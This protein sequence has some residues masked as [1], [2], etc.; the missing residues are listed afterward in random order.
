M[1]PAPVHNPRG[2]I[3]VGMAIALLAGLFLS[4]RFIMGGFPGAAMFI[5][6]IQGGEQ[7]RFPGY[8]RA[9]AKGV[10]IFGRFEASGALS[11][12]SRAPLF[13]QG[14]SVPLLGRFATADGD[15]TAPDLRVPVRSL[16]LAFTQPDGQQ[17][18]TAMNTPPVFPVSSP[19]EF[20]EL[21]ALMKPDP[22]TGKPD[23]S[24]LGQ[25]FATHPESAAMGEWQRAYRPSASFATEI[26]H[27]INAFLLVDG[28]GRQ[29][30]VRWQVEPIDAARA[31]AP[32]DGPPDFLFS[33][34][35]DRLQQG[36]IRFRL[37]FVVAAPGDPVD[38]PTRPWPASRPRI[39]AGTITLDRTTP[40]QGGAC[41]Q[42]TYDPL[43]LVDGIRPSADPILQA[44]GGAY[45]ESYRRRAIEMLEGAQ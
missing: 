26:Y 45:A 18:R 5:D 21:A 2:W 10:C 19:A 36:P 34:L 20:Y 39:D 30:P 15:P 35:A 23:M 6:R 17:W 44:R 22:A 43:V 11:A 9:H 24:K 4:A 33:E 31:D 42:I 12:L 41:D 29:H 13:R 38:D 32:A 14:A 16:A 25:F 7:T 1:K 8:R 3:K 27:S 28:E 40:Q 37:V